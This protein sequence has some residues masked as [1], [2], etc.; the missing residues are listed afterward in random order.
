[1]LTHLAHIP[2]TD[3]QL[4]LAIIFAVKGRVSRAPLLLASAEAAEAA[5]R[6]GGEGGSGS[7]HP[8]LSQ[9]K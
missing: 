4:F 6:E 8:R 3:E 1:M 7:C 9:P 5:H 2:T